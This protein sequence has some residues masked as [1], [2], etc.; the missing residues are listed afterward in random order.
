MHMKTA[1]DVAAT[2]AENA[3]IREEREKKRYD[4]K[5]SLAY[6]WPQCMSGR[7]AE[8]TVESNIRYAPGKELHHMNHSG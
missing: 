2:K 5:T 7:A 4:L 6:D 8:K 1:S 3:G